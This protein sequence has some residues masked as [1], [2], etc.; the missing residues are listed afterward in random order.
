MKQLPA[1]YTGPGLVDLQVNGYAGH[2][3]NGPAESLTAELFAEV[4]TALRRRGVCAVLITFITDA[5]DA[6]LARAERYARIVESDGQLEAQFPLL[7]IEGPFLSD[8]EGPRGIQPPDHLRAPKDSPDFIE[9]VNDASGGR[10][11]LVTLAPELPGAIELIHRCTEAGICVAIGH[12]AA[13]NEQIDAAVE[14]GAKLSTHLGNG[15]HQ[16]LPRLDNYVQKQL[17]EDRLA[18][19]FIADGHHIP[20]TTLKNF[21]RAKTP[22]RSILITDAMAAAEMGPGQYEFGG[23]VAIVQPNGYVSRPGEANLAGSAATLD[24]CIINTY[25]H[26]DVT[27]EQAWAMASTQPAQLVGLAQQPQV[28]VR[29][30]EQG[31]KADWQGS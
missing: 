6:T 11:G 1:T 24:K 29:I 3:F 20:F 28:T 31:F 18:A 19:S 22:A 27:F 7:H 12:T 4:R 26:C 5:A 30:D 25:L 17:A 9:R 8:Q 14:A 21:I 16:M 10:V 15:S 2:S 23:K 13:T